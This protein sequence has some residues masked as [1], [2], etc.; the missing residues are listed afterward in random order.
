MDKS[1][2]YRFIRGETH[3]RGAPE[4]R[5]RHNTFSRQDIRKLQ[6]ACVRLIRAA[7]SEEG[8]TWEDVLEEAALDVTP[9]FANIFLSMC[10]IFS[11]GRSEY[12]P[13][14]G[15]AMHEGCGM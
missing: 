2:V 14:R 12:Q 6:Q 1:T 13:H 8:V 4:T 15:V 7:D 5:G 11:L 10:S 3:V 9:S